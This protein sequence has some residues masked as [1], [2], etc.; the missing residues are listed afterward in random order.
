MIQLLEDLPKNV[1]G[2]EAVGKVTSDDYEQTIVP[3]IEEKQREY[4]KVRLIYVLGPEY[5]GY[6]P[7]AM[8]D[9]SMLA[10][11]RPGSWEKI[12]VVSD[13]E[14]LNRAIGAFSWMV[15][16]EVKLF[17]DSELDAARNWVS[18]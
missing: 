6:T 4:D 10:F 11:K 8:W 1:I 15:P 18:N 12:A 9:D 13:H 2:L 17:H 7:G 16:G 5:E 14:W 3:Q